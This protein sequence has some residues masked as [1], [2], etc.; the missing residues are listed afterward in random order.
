MKNRWALL[1]AVLMTVLLW[2]FPDPARTAALDS[3]STWFYSVVPGLFPF[4]VLLPALTCPE[5]AQIYERMLGRA[6]Q[7]LFGLSGRTAAALGISLLSGSPAGAA[8]LARLDADQPFAPDE[9]LRAAL[10][11]S[12]CNP[13][14]LTGAVASGFLSR[15]ELGWVLV[16]SQILALI[17]S[18]VLLRRVGKG[19]SLPAR[20]PAPSAQPTPAIKGAVLQILGIGGCM[21]FF[22]VIARLAALCAALLLPNVNLETPLIC[23]LELGG[24]CASLCALPMSD[25]LRIPLLSAVIGFSGLSICIQSLGYLKPMGVRAR[26]FLLGK[27]LHALLCAGFSV[28][29]MRLKAPAAPAFAPIS[30][31]SPDTP[32]FWA[33]L[34]AG[35]LL[36]P[37]LLGRVFSWRET[38]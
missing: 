18:G 1:G 33:V 21:V 15:P 8:A 25:G 22:G 4:F 36:L 14:F 37:P 28:L 29:I 9:A 32:L 30:A 24:G 10:L 31:G 13:L 3:L 20:S 34:S 2:C 26:D 12:G 27:G 6:M 19:K 17:T 38:R 23:F 16:L 5:A 35:C 7:P 11:C